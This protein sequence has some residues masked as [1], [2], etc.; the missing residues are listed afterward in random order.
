MKDKLINI[1][2]SK[3]QVEEIWG[4]LSTLYSLIEDN[5]IKDEKE[6]NDRNREIK[7]CKRLEKRF[8]NELQKTKDI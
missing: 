7:A 3:K 1:K 2:L 4:C 5:P 8:Y 6:W